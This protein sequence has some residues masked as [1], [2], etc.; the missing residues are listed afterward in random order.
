MR[1]VSSFLVG[2]LFGGGLIVSGM[3]NPSKVLGF[4][5]LADHWDPSLAF[6]MIGAI[7]FASIGFIVSKRIGKPLLD[8]TTHLPTKKKIDAQLILG[9]AIFGVGWGGSGI[10]SRTGHGRGGRG[11]IRC[12]DLP[13]GNA[14]RHARFQLVRRSAN[15][16]GQCECALG[17]H[18]VR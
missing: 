12:C 6:V 3:A 18:R 9:S 10:L 4:L 2:L 17:R 7:T 16:P 15:H 5:D 13:R 11:K 1:N 14:C 8:E